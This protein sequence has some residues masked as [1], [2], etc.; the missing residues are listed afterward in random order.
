V[1]EMT[2]ERARQILAGATM[3][4]AMLEAQGDMDGHVLLAIEQA[5]AFLA[6]HARAE[7]AEE[8]VKGLEEKAGL[9]QEVERLKQTLAR[10]RHQHADTI[11]SRDRASEAADRLAYALY[12]VEEIG[13]HT[14]MNDPW[15]N[16]AERLESSA[17]LAPTQEP[18]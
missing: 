9:R 3:H 14:N 7:A 11:D 8:R 4:N 10:E 2:P 1:S 6:Q 16:A 17:A 5:T 13:E 18:S 15:L 12:S